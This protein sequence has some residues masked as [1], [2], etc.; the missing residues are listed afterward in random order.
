MTKATTAIGPNTRVN[1]RIIGDTTVDVYGYV[2]GEIDLRDTLT[3]HEQAVIDGDIAADN[4]V[5]KGTVR[6]QLRVRNHLVLGPSA[7]VVATIRTHLFTVENGAIVSGNIETHIGASDSAK[8]L[9]FDPHEFDHTPSNI[10]PVAELDSDAYVLDSEVSEVSEHHDDS[11]AYLLDSEASEVIEHHDDEILELEEAHEVGNDDHEEHEGHEESSESFYEDV[12]EDAEKKAEGVATYDDE[13]DDFDAEATVALDVAADPY[14]Q[15]SSPEHSQ[16]HEASDV[17]FASEA[18]E[19]SDAPELQES[20]SVESF[21]STDVAAPIDDPDTY[22]DHQVFAV[23]PNEDEILDRE[24]IRDEYA[25]FEEDDEGE[26]TEE[27]DLRDYE[28]AQLYHHT[29]SNPRITTDFS[30]PDR[31]S[32]DYHTLEEDSHSLLEEDDNLDDIRSFDFEPGDVEGAESVVNP[33]MLK[34]PK[35]D[36]FAGILDEPSEFD[37][38]GSTKT[39]FVNFDD[40]MPDEVE[41]EDVQESHLDDVM[42]EVVESSEYVTFEDI[43]DMREPSSINANSFDDETRVAQAP[44]APTAFVHFDDTTDVNNLSE[45]LSVQ[46]LHD[47]DDDGIL[48]LSDDAVLEL[49]DD[50]MVETEL[51]ETDNQA[52]QDL[53]DML[54]EFEAPHDGDDFATHI[55]I[56]MFPDSEAIADVFEDDSD[57]EDT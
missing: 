55:D 28:R 24:A 37:V 48:E 40:G 4:I 7:R 19:V 44:E 8:P 31:E 38:Q 57:I 20:E 9:D 15:D 12:K 18:S 34:R 25:S 5:V 39:P 16:A 22:R 13:D 41:F 3:V 27:L 53:R 29:I 10:Q 2:R 14:A 33:Y 23:Q 36:S 21:V 45:E 50:D 56:D 35:F 42:S 26:V 47:M 54:T 49:S 46:T 43:A 32:G 52:F 51:I 11:D 1:G 30:Q 6:G 17:S